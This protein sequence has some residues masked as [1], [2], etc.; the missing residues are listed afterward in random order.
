[1]EYISPEFNFSFLND[2]SFLSTS[3]NNNTGINP[4]ENGTSPVPS[5]PRN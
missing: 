5:R 4:D 3:G 2:G 1:M